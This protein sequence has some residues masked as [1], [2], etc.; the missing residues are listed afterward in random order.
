M[1]GR[2]ARHDGPEPGPARLSSAAGSAVGIASDDVGHFGGRHRGRATGRT[3][4]AVRAAALV[5]ERPPRVVR[6]VQA[7]NTNS[8]ALIQLLLR[9]PASRAEMASRLGL[10]QGAVTRISAS[11][12][13]AGLVR[14]LDSKGPG[15][16]AQGSLGGRPSIPLGLVGD[17][18]FTVGVHF[19]P[20]ATTVGLT[21]LRGH[22]LRETTLHRPPGSP[23]AAIAQ[24][25]ELARQV[26]E[27]ALGRLAGVGVTTDGWVDDSAGVVRR[28]DRLG[29]TDVPVRDQ[30]AARLRLPVAVDSHVRGRT[31]AELLFGAARRGGDITYLLVG[32]AL[33]LGLSVH[34]VVRVGAAAAEGSFG[35][36][37][38][39]VDALGGRCARLGRVATDR[40]VVDTAR[41]IGVLDPGEGWDQ[42]AT[43]TT[44]GIT[45]RGRTCAEL[46]RERARVVGYGIGQ[47]VPLLDPDHLV[48]G[49]SLLVIPEHPDEVRGAA[50]RIAGGWLDVE[51]IMPSG[52]GPV[53]T[54]HRVRGGRAEP[55]YAHPVSWDA[56]AAI[57]LEP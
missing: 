54:G 55:H 44:D 3:G 49:G 5:S 33:E 19:G 7:R 4:R 12:T 35:E 27:P 22:C 45:S 47:L 25:A 10:S 21:D 9:T 23:A 16:D 31:R 24:A 43:L 34:P 50:R 1:S 46:L 53:L 56:M 52:L 41:R 20:A 13:A 51:R 8:A 38:V 15:G 48:L 11:L 32:D 57:G 6:P 36:L 40:A 26:L 37:M 29:R 39:P 28:N 17:A 42:L 18:R 30:P 2:T 14:E